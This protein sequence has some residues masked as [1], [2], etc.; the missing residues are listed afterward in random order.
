MKPSETNN[1]AHPSSAC[2]HGHGHGG[3]GAGQPN[4]PR[5]IAWEMTEDCQLKCTH[6][7]IGEGCAATRR[8]MNTAESKRV[9]DSIAPHYKPILIMTGGN[10]LLRK[11][12]FELAAYGTSLGMRTV[13]ASCGYGMSRE[14]VEKLKESGIQRVS[15][16][17]DAAKPEDHDRF[18]GETGSY[19]AVMEAAA[20]CRDG[21][22]GFQIN[23]TVTKLNRHELHTIYDM[24][25]EMGAVEFHPFFFVPTGSGQGQHNLSLDAEEYETVLEEI[26]GLNAQGT[27][28]VFKPTCA[29]QYAR[30]FRQQHPD[31]DRRLGGAGCMGGK[32]FAF[33]S[34]SG[35][36]KI[37]GFLSVIA[38]DLR[39]VDFDFHRVWTESELFNNLRDFKRYEGKCG[40]CAYRVACGGCRARAYEVRGSYLEEEPFCAYPGK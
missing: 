14:T 36:V 13:L 37:C 25:R 21:D 22:L 32:S 30:I 8:E 26:A 31:G 7:R 39:E 33:I 5:L 15:F 29:P 24:A 11:D 20:F 34:A 10:P 9:L 16:S 27:P 2:G 18:R 6:C 17:I 1:S 3:H 38:G 12:F 4:I 40:T 23:T 28:M 19:Q 35:Q